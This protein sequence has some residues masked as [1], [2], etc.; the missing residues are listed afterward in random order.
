M[1]S[2]ITITDMSRITLNGVEYIIGFDGTCVALAT[3]MGRIMIEGKDLKIES[4]EKKE[5]LITVTGSIRG[6]F[7]S[8]KNAE[9]GFLKRIFK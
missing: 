1:S 6:T 7:I 8:E 4:L 3:S 5:G 9:A 2:L